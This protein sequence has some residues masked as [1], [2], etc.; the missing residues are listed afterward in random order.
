MNHIGSSNPAPPLRPDDRELLS[1][2][3]DGECPDAD[4]VSDLLKQSAEARQYL[5]QLRQA[6]DLYHTGRRVLSG[7]AEAAVADILRR[8]RCDTDSNGRVFPAFRKRP[9]VLWWW[10]AAAAV[11]MVAAGGLFLRQVR[12]MPEV[13]PDQA[14]TE[15]RNAAAAAL[16]GD[17]DLAAL[18]R[19][20]LRDSSDPVDLWEN[21]PE[22]D[23]LLY[24]ALW[25]EETAESE[26]PEDSGLWWEQ[27][28][29]LAAL[30]DSTAMGDPMQTV[31][32][33]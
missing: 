32:Q 25:E 5:E 1:A 27:A 9:G 10:A 8:I 6:Q 7:D 30:F 24:A 29:R 4:R 17:A 21:L 15:D 11:L 18:L 22:E 2:W 14:D 20:T 23:L 16:I 13:Y 33:P 31:P 12:S 28:E 3:L 19:E 26:E